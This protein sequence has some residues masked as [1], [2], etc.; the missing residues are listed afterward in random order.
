LLFPS[1]QLTRHFVSTRT[2]PGSSV[3][4]LSALLFPSPDFHAGCVPLLDTS[5]EF[6]IFPKFSNGTSSSCGSGRN[7]YRNLLGVL[8]PEAIVPRVPTRIRLNMG[9]SEGKEAAMMPTSYSMKRQMVNVSC[10]YGSGSRRAVFCFSDLMI[11][12]TPAKR[13]RARIQTRGIFVRPLSCSSHTSGMGKRA[14]RKS[15]AMVTAKL[16]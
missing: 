12:A 11:A 9:L 6:P 2:A 15:V 14:R 1:S 4:T 13:P 7:V 16:G 5:T 8:W 3:L 10:T